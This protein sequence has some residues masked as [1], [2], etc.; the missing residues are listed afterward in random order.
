MPAPVE[1]FSGSAPPGWDEI[2]GSLGGN[3]FHS[4]IWADY[5]RERG[6]GEPVFFLARDGAGRPLG[7]AL[8]LFRR[9]RRPLLSLLLRS[10]AVTAH[11][12]GF[13]SDPEGLAAFVARCEGAAR[14]LGCAN[15]SLGSNMSGDS[16]FLPAEHG[17]AESLR[18]EFHADLRR[19]REE[20][21]SDVAKDQRERVQALPR[22]GIVVEEGE[23]R[24]AL[25]GLQMVRESTQE[26]R[27]RRGQGYELAADDLYDTLYDRLLARGAAR[28]FVARH[29][30]E[31]VAAILFSAFNG[32]AYSVFSGSTDLGYKAGAQSG[33]FWKSVETFRGEGFWRLN[34]GGVPAS[35]ER[36]SDPLHGIYRF[37]RRL[38]TVPVVCRSGEKVVNRWRSAA[39]R[40]RES[41]RR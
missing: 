24:G 34:R 13:K 15:L 27:S 16:P 22:K 14:D 36:E 7:G 9:S 18:F 1:V 29:E 21:W 41:V 11:P 40:I 31:V 5:E 12:F 25:G 38:G 8:C 23:G 32:Q 20:L 28:L 6:A 17:Y 2:V 3:I 30:G 19:E 33:L 4:S 39:Q 37:K 26:K 10:L 35:A